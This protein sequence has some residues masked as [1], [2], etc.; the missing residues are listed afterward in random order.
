MILQGV[1]QA[2]MTN[3]VRYYELALQVA[4]ISERAFNS[5][6]SAAINQVLQAFFEMDALTQMALMD[7]FVEFDK[8][9]W[10][11]SLTGPFLAR[12]F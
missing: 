6:A 1:S 12:L 5:M 9:P 3:M 8:M 10:T 4:T 7:F 2:N 11:G